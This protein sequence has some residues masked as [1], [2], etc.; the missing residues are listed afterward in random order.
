M[1][2]DKQ[3][4]PHLK[5]LNGRVN[6]QLY[7]Y[8]LGY[9]P[10]VLES[11]RLQRKEGRSRWTFAKKL[12]L[13]I[14]SITGFSVKPLRLI[15]VIGIFVSL[16]SFSYG[17]FVF[18]MALINENRVPGFAAMYV[19]VSFFGGLIVSMLAIIGEYIWRIFELVNQKPTRVI[20]EV[21][22]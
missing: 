7:T 21:L 9:T 4:L 11:D 3:I 5:N 18:I 19:L 10:K 17:S 14:N 8:W 1:L 13:F 12:D 6:Y 2:M 22:L 15:S 20:D 16:L